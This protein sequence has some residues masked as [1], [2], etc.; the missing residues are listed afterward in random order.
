VTMTAVILLVLK[1]SIVLSVFAIGLRATFAHATSLFRRPDQL[2]RAFVSMNVLMPLMALAVGAPFDLHPA[3]KIALV[4]IAV[5]PTPP[6]FPKKALDAGGTEA[7][8]IGLLVAVAVLSVVVIPLSME[9]LAAMTGI[10]LAMPARSVAVLVLITIL[11]PLVAGIAVRRFATAAADRA[12]GPIAV[13][14][15]VLLVASAM[16][17]V[18]GV[19]RTVWSLVTDGTILG[20]G[21]FAAAGFLIGHVLGGPE[22]ANRPVLGLAT[23][24][25]H[26]AVALAI[27]HANFP[28]QGLASAA[29]FL[30]VML[31]GVLSALYLA[32]VNRTRAGARV[33]VLSWFCIAALEISIT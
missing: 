16:P 20:L 24:T 31:A 12:A 5:S 28:E 21:G 30:Y 9:V 19:S 2:L 17:I 29:V 11:A 25:R 8:T 23:A 14:A 22:P 3:V 10:S 32:W 18:I 26:P 4:V 33:T 7:C 27:A 1:A 13:L 6:I 15:T